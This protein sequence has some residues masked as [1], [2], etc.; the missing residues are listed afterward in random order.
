MVVVG[1]SLVMAACCVP[2]CAHVYAPQH[3]SSASLTVLLCKQVHRPHGAAEGAAA[4]AAPAAVVTA[5]GRDGTE[6]GAGAT[7]GEGCACGLPFAIHGCSTMRPCR[8][9]H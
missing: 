1:C 7:A 3:L 6:G 5:A 9:E 2:G 4:A 8:E